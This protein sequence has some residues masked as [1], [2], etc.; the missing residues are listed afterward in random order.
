MTLRGVLRR[1][2]AGA[3]RPCQRAF[4]VYPHHVMQT[5]L[6]WPR[7]SES[8]RRRI[9]GNTHFIAIA[10]GDKIRGARRAGG[11]GVVMQLA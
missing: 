7:S 10:R 8:W 6:V 11:L 1:H 9:S 2:P 4:H 5:L 3:R